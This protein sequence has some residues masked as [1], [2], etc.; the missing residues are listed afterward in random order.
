MHACRSRELTKSTDMLLPIDQ[1]AYRTFAFTADGWSAY[2]G[3]VF[4][5][6]KHTPLPA[7]LAARNLPAGFAE[8]W[9][10]HRDGLAV[11]HALRKYAS[12]FLRSFYA[13]E[14][15]L[16]ADEEVLASWAHW[17][18]QSSSSRLLPNLA[19]ARLLGALGDVTRG[20]E[21][22]SSWD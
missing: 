14:E 15:A 18:T 2:F 5:T 1:F 22:T 20:N 10:L 11:W 13:D 3:D 16:R 9:P 17:E 6:W 4:K 7:S 19:G 21:M 12:A 8:A